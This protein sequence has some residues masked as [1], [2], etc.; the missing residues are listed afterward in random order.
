VLRFALMPGL[1]YVKSADPGPDTVTTGY[2]PNQLS[3][4]TA[5][6]RL[7]QVE[8]PLALS[9]PLV[10][11][12]LLPGPQADVLVLANWSGADIAALDVTIRGGERYDS[13]ESLGGSRLTA[14]RREADL[15]FSL[16]LGETDVVVL[17]TD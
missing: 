17:K 3:V 4:L 2:H 6:L 8:P 11:A 7:A 13:A 1:G 10:E 14:E 9:T 15:S 5:G 12:Q 16:T